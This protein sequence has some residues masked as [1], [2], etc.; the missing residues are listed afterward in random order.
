MAIY[1]GPGGAGDAT[2]DATNASA[3]AL[4]AKDEAQASATAAANSATAAA[5]SATS[6]ANDAASASSSAT[7]A[8]I[9][10]T[11]AAA[12]ATQAESVLSTA[13][14]LTGDQT[15][16]GVK[17]F[18]STIAGSI[19][20]NAATV[21]NGV[22]TT[23]DQ[24]I[25]G[26]KTFSSTISGS[27]NGNAATVTNG[28]YTTG[29][30][31]IAGTKTFLSTISGSING[32]AS[33]ATSATTA[34]TAT[35]VSGGTASVTTLTTSSTVTHNGGIA[36]RLTYLNGSKVLS[37]SDILVFDGA[38]LG[39]NVTPPTSVSSSGG[40]YLANTANIAATGPY[41]HF[42]ANYYY[43]L[44]T[45]KYTSTAPAAA[46]SSYNGTHLWRVA[47]SGTADTTITWTTALTLDANADM[48]LPKN[49]YIGDASNT[50]SQ[51]SSGSSSNPLIFGINGTEKARLDTTG[52]LGIGVTP[53]SWS[54]SYAKAL[55][56][57]NRGAAVSGFTSSYAVYPYANVT[58]NSYFGS[59]GT[60]KYY[61]GGYGAC[62]Y[63]QREH[64]HRWSIAG[65][66]TTG[67][68]ITFTQAM[69]L[70]SSGYLG[71]G[72][73]SPGEKLQVGSG[74]ASSNSV[75]L[76][77]GASTNSYGAGIKLQKNNVNVGF[78]GSASWM[79]GGT[80]DDLAFSANS[81]ATIGMRLNSSGNLGLGVTPSAWT[82]TGKT[83]QFKYAAV[84]SDNTT[85]SIELS[86]NAYY[87]GS[88]KY[89]QAYTAGR[90][91]ISNGA[92]FWYTAASGT[93]GNAITFTQA[94]TLDASGNLGVGT[95]S[96]GA[97]L[98]VSSASSAVAG[99]SKSGSQTVYAVSYA[100]NAGI[101]AESG[102]LNAVL[103]SSSNN[104]IQLYTNNAE[105]ARIDSSGNLLVG[106]TSV[107]GGSKLTVSTAS[108][109][110]ASFVSTA[111]ADSSTYG[112]YVAKF[113]NDSTTSQRFVG[114]SINNDTA[115]SGQINANGA[116]Q[117]AFG[118]FSDARLK[119]NIVDLSPQLASIMALRPVEFDYK[120]G[121]HQTGFIAQEMQSVF[122]DAVGEADGFLTVTGWNKTEAILVKAIQEQQAIIESLKA[123]L[124]AANL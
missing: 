44:T 73:S 33:T 87:D 79:E 18:S 1:R 114:F 20:G 110:P 3:L 39:L 90:Y 22:Y 66:G 42:G 27:I 55:Q 88:W 117:A 64:E 102:G 69:T 32:N 75:L 76:L 99:F 14:K 119:E 89:I 111:A 7:S 34:T 9:S 26:T 104:L 115:G 68:S 16:A 51:I 78:I 59:D 61:D 8:A 58:N 57:G 95:T 113:A 83:I 5:S 2:G 91:A 107:F 17:T 118:S 15:V 50:S 46:Y 19:N 122:P 11:A 74:S 12:S 30:Q 103:L 116:S 97:R 25:A 52:N 43:V 31:T 49:F 105:R 120:T 92:H 35:N 121:G 67:S 109:R 10:R 37:T 65:T 21:T 71:I 36:N 13:V 86:S 6:A 85:D 60:W 41:L 101:A 81:G 28:V 100:S 53:S 106:T 23:G 63:Q 93:A 54:S 124:D 48:Y 45:P 98:D 123:R 112:I 4:A 72:T 96:P 82:N 47:P 62:L 24:T 70:N 77:N 84:S 40:I 94:M 80:S 38:N 108:G 29:D 56:L